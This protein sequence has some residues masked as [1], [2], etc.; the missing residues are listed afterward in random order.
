MEEQVNAAFATSLN[1]LIACHARNEHDSVV[2]EGLTQHGG[3]LPIQN[4]VKL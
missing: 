2:I 3:V 1:H 4:A